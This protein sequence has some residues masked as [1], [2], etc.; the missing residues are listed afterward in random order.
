MEKLEAFFRIVKEKNLYLH[1]LELKLFPGE[2]KWCGRIFTG[3]SYRM[4]PSRLDGL[5]I[6]HLPKTADEL[7]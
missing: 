7:S 5:K 6:M 4:D 3:E 2:F 1:A